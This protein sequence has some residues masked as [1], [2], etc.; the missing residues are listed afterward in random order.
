MPVHDRSDLRSRCI[1][2]SGATG[3]I[4]QAL[5]RQLAAQGVRLH[6]LG[7]RMGALEQLRASLPAS[8]AERCTLHSMDIT[9]DE[10]RQ[11]LVRRLIHLS[12]LEQPDALINLAGL[13]HLAMFED[14][15]EEEWGALLDINL[16]ATM[17][18]TQRLLPLLKRAPAAN[19][20][21]V[22]SMLGHIG[23]PGYVAYCTSKF[24][25][26]GFSEALAR[27]LSDSPVRV[28]YLAPRTTA[29]AMNSAA[30]DA[31]NKD[32]G[33]TTDTPEHVAA[34]IVTLLKSRRSRHRLGGRER[35][36]AKLNELVPGLV[37]KG[38]GGKLSIIRRHAKEA[39]V[40]DASRESAYLTS[41]SEPLSSTQV[42]G[43]H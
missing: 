31:L 18:L 10:D 29:T 13:N 43:E 24:A 22:G 32:L 27:E 28:Q 9:Q 37:D 34:H 14:M 6:L 12:A 21:N 11:R 26:R 38:L 33:N 36:F 30:A 23:H 8:A 17:A 40:Q 42:L 39:L 16:V 4:G 20:L 15:R 5:V 1:V 41:P 19:I 7:R 2:I 25:L 35:V 3:G